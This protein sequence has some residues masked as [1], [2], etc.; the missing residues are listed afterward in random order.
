MSLY[1]IPVAPDFR[2]TRFVVGGADDEMDLIRRLLGRAIADGLQAEI[3]EAAAGPRSE[4]QYASELNPC[5]GDVWIECAPAMQ[6]ACATCNGHGEVDGNHCPACGGEGWFAGRRLL[7]FMRATRIDHHQ[8][9]DSGYKVAGFE[10]SSLGQVLRLLLEAGAH[11]HTLGL[12]DLD[13]PT[14]MG[15]PVAWSDCGGVYGFGWG[16][17]ISEG[18]AYGCPGFHWFRLPPEWEA[19]GWADHDPVGFLRGGCTRFPPSVARAWLIARAVKAG[20]GVTEADVVEALA[21]IEA[22]PTL[23]GFPAAYDLRGIPELCP[24]TMG[25]DRQPVPGTGGRLGSAAFVAVLAMPGKAALNWGAQGIRPQGRH[26]GL[27]GDTS[28][29]DGPA[30]LT[31]V[32]AVGVYGA[33]GKACGGYVQLP[34]AVQICNTC[35]GPVY[36]T[37][38]GPECGCGLGLH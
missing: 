17:H 4:A 7:D 21:M 26:L 33:T 31:S 15:F 27:I 22:A 37:A 19:I 28:G 6:A 2:P 9:G 35:Q 38:G 36:A 29:L 1:V 30:I 23:P 14:I 12:W 16:V 20:R 13:D 5:N 25:A 11:P 34:P 10:G 3:V 32:G 8:P 18:E 24:A